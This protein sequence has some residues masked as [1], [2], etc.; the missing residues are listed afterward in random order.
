MLCSRQSARHAAPCS[1]SFRF[2]PLGAPA[3]QPLRREVIQ[4]LAQFMLRRKFHLSDVWSMTKG[5]GERYGAGH[6][7]AFQRVVKLARLTASISAVLTILCAALV[8]GLQVTSWNRTGVWEAY[9][10]SSAIKS[11]KGDRADVYFTA[12]SG[13]FQTE[14]TNRQVLV[15]WLLGIPTVALLLAVAALHIVFYLYLAVIEQEATKH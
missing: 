12:S 11:L 4:R 7:S 14:L 1:V 10:L 13:K 3:V 6:L 8:F 9:P 5:A 2:L 15:D